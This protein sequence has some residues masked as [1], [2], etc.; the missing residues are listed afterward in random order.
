MQA[1]IRF[2]TPVPPEDVP[3]DDPG[4]TLG[5]GYWRT[6]AGPE[7]WNH[8][9]EVSALLPLWL[10]EPGGDASVL[11]GEAEIA[12]EILAFKTP[13]GPA[14]G[15]IALRAALLAVKLNVAR[16]AEDADIAQA[17]GE[18]DAFLASHGHGDWPA[19]T[20]SEQIQVRG[21][22]DLCESYNE[23]EIGPGSCASKEPQ[24]KR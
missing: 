18:A 5:L 16:G 8:P 4:C 17:V 11:V 10:G 12:R 21:W 19:L 23:G 7:S 2:E 14:N 15:I 22:K 9:D 3:G 1:L 6:H 24:A 20:K 13:G